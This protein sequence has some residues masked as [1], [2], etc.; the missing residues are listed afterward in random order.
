M[1]FGFGDYINPH[2]ESVELLE[3][4]V[5]EVNTQMEF[6]D[7]RDTDDAV[8]EMNGRELLGCRVSV[9]H[10]RSIP[11][12]GEMGGSVSVKR[13]AGGWSDRAGVADRAGEQPR[14]RAP[15]DW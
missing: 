14:A 13:P 4:V 11:R 8:Y 5:I 12:R 9:E 3:D 1:M 2:T 6:E 15:P 7:H 10:A